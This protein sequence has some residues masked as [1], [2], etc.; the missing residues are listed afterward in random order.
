MTRETTPNGLTASLLRE[1]WECIFKRHSIFRT[2]FDLELGSQTVQDSIQLHWKEYTVSTPEELKVVSEQE[3]L[4]LWA[5]L[6]SPA[7]PTSLLGPQFWIVEIP[8][9]KIQ[10]NSVIHHIYMDAWSFGILLVDL[11]EVIGNKERH[12]STPSFASLAQFLAAKK[13]QERDKVHRFWEQY[14]THWSQLQ[15]VKLSAPYAP[16][17]EPWSIWESDTGVNKSI[18]DQFASSAG[19][20]SAACIFTAWA[21]LLTQYTSS[22]TVG[23]KISVSGR[24]LDFPFVDS[25]VGPLNGRCPFIATI[26]E[27]SSILTTAVSLHQNF[28]R[29]NE[30]QWSYP[31]LRRQIGP[32]ENKYSFDSQIVVLLDM[33]VEPGP[34]KVVE[35]QKP[36]AP[37]WLGVAQKGETIDLRLR[38]D[39]SRYSA[40]GIQQ[41]AW[42]FITGLKALVDSGED[43][44]VR[45]IT[46]VM[47]SMC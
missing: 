10:I 27:N 1:G 3:R 14:S 19:I 18:L 5:K 21:L 8:G 12:S 6:R 28:Y 44:L 11:E 17:T 30:F 9:Q 34:W 31:E 42:S 22:S 43:T 35:T 20:S 47:G 37:L 16:S 7:D 45:D 2:T 25:I 38:Y 23:M 41:M 15:Y 24:N 33:P 39:G 46:R 36:T 4:G 32:Q 40:E 26:D 13:I 29:V